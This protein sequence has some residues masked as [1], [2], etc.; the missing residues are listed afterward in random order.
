M[1]A[2]RG[3]GKQFGTHSAVRDL[4]LDVRR[5][6]TLALLGPNGSGK[7]TTLKAAA[8]LIT[9]TAGHV[10]LGEP[11]RNARVPSARDLVSYLPQRV[12]FPEALTG[13]DVIEFYRRLRGTHASRTDVVLRFAS[14]NG[15]AGRAVGT[16]SGGM[17]Q[18]L[19]LAVAV[20]PDAPVFL[21]DEPTAALDPDGLAAFYTIVERHAAEGRTVLFTSHQL[22]DVERLADRFAVLVSGRLVAVLTQRELHDR[23]AERGV[24]RVRTAGLCGDAVARLAAVAP[25]SHVDA[26][27]VVVPGP[28]WRRP[29]ALDAL[30]DAGVEIRGLTAEEGRL[31][32]FYRELIGDST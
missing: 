31:D 22:G 20:L 17:T 15:A 26:D 32:T 16:Y 29:A 18:R 6:E 19:G 11:G 30:R 9:P 7:T 2:F 8:G 28:P 25:G 10:L 14:L 24:M 1:I 4:T 27:E 5:G 3:F 12:S 13:R 21:L 23:L